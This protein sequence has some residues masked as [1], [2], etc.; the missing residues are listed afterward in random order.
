MM[1]LRKTPNLHDKYRQL[2]E[3]LQKHQENA[4][5][6]SHMLQSKLSDDAAVMEE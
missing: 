6:M 2:Q 1:Q 5:N 4:I 3:A